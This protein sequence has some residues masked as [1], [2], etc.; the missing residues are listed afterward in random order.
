MWTIDGAGEWNGAG[1]NDDNWPFGPSR[2]LSPLGGWE[3]NKRWPQAR[4]SFSGRKGF[5]TPSQFTMEFY[6]YDGVT[7]N[8]I[9]SGYILSGQP[10]NITWNGPAGDPDF[11]FDSLWCYGADATNYFTVDQIEFLDCS[12]SSSVSSS[13]ISFSSSSSSLSTSSSSSSSSLSNSSSSSSSSESTGLTA[14]NYFDNTF[15][16]PV[17]A[18]SGTWTGSVWTQGFLPAVVW[19]AP[20]GVWNVGFNP[21]SMDITLDNSE[22]GS[23][24]YDFQIQ[25]TN[26]PSPVQ[27]N[28]VGPIT[29]GQTVNL[30]LV[31]GGDTPFELQVD[32]PGVDF[33]EITNIVFYA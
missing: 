1:W 12:S 17:N 27:H 4:V 5:P 26:A 23:A 28:S 25:F 13:S 21:V 16:A 3:I 2:G 6:D 8:T 29:D 31:A 14:Y 15:W 18:F 11:D 32:A 22:F 20:I 19:L 30:S 33:F 9:F 10:F 7:W 24:T